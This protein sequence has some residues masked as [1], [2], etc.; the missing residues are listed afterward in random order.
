[1]TLIELRTSLVDF[2]EH[3]LEQIDRYI[4][5]ILGRLIFG[6]LFGQRFKKLGY[7]LLEEFT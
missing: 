5:E 3:L 6:A 4:V 1:L 7:F 2:N